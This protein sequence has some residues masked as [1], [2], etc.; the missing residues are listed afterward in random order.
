[1]SIGVPEWRDWA[2]YVKRHPIQ[3]KAPMPPGY[4]G[5]VTEKARTVVAHPGW[6]FFLDRLASR[7]SALTK[8]R[9][10]LRSKALGP[11]GET[12]EE[13]T[14]RVVR[15]LAQQPKDRDLMDRDAQG[16]RRRGGY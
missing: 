2:E 1:M 13:A 4:V 14:R 5:E 6:Q 16:V 15:Q 10:S 12:I 11:T 3:G 7:Q 8:A 9:E